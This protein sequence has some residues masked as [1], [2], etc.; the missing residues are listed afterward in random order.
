MIRWFVIVLMCALIFG[1]IGYAYGSYF[2]SLECDKIIENEICAGFKVDAGLQTVSTDTRSISDK[3]LETQWK[4]N[5]T[6]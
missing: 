4:K 3:I 6:Q 5:E 1:A 2:S